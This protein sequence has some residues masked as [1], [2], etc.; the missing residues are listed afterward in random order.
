MQTFK[1]SVVGSGTAGW[2][3]AL[4][5]NKYYP[6]I[7][8]E[9]IASS[10][11]GILGAGEGTT[12][13][14]LAFL[15]SLNIPIEDFFIYA[16]ATVKNGIK[17]TNWNGDN[18]S[19][20]HGFSNN[21]NFDPFAFDN[22]TGQGIPAIILEQIGLE[23]NLND[24][25]IDSYLS[26][27]CR[28]KYVWNQSIS[29][30]LDSSINHFNQMGMHAIH[31]D[32]VML[33]D[34]LKQ[35]A[36]ARGVIYI[37]D[38]VVGFNQDEN[39][40]ITGIVTKEK[41]EIKTSFVF[42]CS[43][44]RRLIIGDLYKA[45][46]KSYKEHLPMKKAIGFFMELDDLSEIP[47]MTE[48][49]AMEYGWVWKIPTQTRFGCGYAFDSDYITEEQAKE[50]I[51][52]T[53]GENVTFGKTF[54][55]DA[56]NFKTPW[57]KNCVAIGLS[58]GFIEPLEAT[59]IMISILSLNSFLDHT[60]GMIKRNQ[61]YIDRY[62]ERME[63]INQE[64]MEFIYAHYLGQRTSSKFW[65][66]FRQKNTIPT[67]VQDILDLSK[68]TMPDKMFLTNRRKTLLYDIPSWYSILTGLR[69]FDK[70]IA[71]EYVESV[72]NDVRGDS[73]EL[74]RRQFHLNLAV[75][76]DNFIKHSDFIEYIKTP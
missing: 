55:Y 30:K 33:A 45:E 23:K 65:Q 42:D 73:L 31:F 37:D 25:I 60:L 5:L 63:D 76:K 54:N 68:I 7:R 3:T 15:E 1:F 32:A 22:V 74:H 9:V 2:I 12:P 75:N 6:Y 61:F 36:I 51:I 49:I 47:S 58:S 14:V 16:N 34:Y 41:G 39:E 53:F 62:N 28:V 56:G 70:D 17:F 27:T 38:E 21:K 19:Y 13:N 29:N 35:I 46:W 8:T 24:V 50:E 67:R 69:I 20:F 18:T 72:I 43:G 48:A 71:I 66:E 64:N 40:Y 10:E 44:F 59:S 4:F 26:D 57:V 11:I 52:N